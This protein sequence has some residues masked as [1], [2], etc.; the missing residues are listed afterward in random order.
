MKRYP[1]LYLA[2]APKCG[3][4]SL[5][6]YLGQHPDIYAPLVKEP[7]F[8]GSDLTASE[9]G[10]AKDAYLDLYSDWG[11]EKYALD[12][13][14]A[15]FFSR[16]A[17]AEIAAAAPDAQILMLVRNPV[18][19][20]HSM[21]HQNR[22]NGNE[23]LE[24]FEASLD[25]E[26]ERVRANIAPRS[27]LAENF[28][29][30]RI[31]SYAENIARYRAVFGTQRVKVILLDDL[32]AAPEALFAEVAVHLGIEAAPKAGISFA[33]RNTSKRAR[34]R[35]LNMMSATPP[36]WAGRIARPFLSRSARLKLRALIGRLNT[37]PQA[38]PPMDKATRLRLSRQFEPE[39]LRLSK[40]LDR[41]LTYWI[42]TDDHG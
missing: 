42:E 41:D 4:T 11:A 10:I 19:A 31:Y 32:K 18:E 34:S 8:F 15:Y 26:A 2:G 38:N 16:S 27:G 21:Y 36:K 39:I 9:P 25:A 29:Y 12:A 30:T 37:V 6:Y 23:P 35:W 22:F 13:S 20:I 3:T 7:R 33:A 1:N 40:I 5:A 24:D 14:T 17:P 28:H